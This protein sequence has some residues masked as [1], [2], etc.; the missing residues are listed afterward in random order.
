MYIEIIKPGLFTSLQQKEVTGFR[1]MG[2]GPGGAM[3]ELAATAAN[4]LV[5]NDA[6][7]FL[8]EIHFPGPELLF[9]CDTLI[10]FTGGDLQATVNGEPLKN[11]QTHFI[12]KKSTVSFSGLKK[13][14]RAYLSVYGGFNVEANNL[15]LFN[16]TTPLKKGDRLQL[17]KPCDLLPGTYEAAILPELYNQVYTTEEF[18]YCIP[19]P[20]WELLSTEA[21]QQLRNASFTISIQSNRMGYRLNGVAVQHEHASMLSSAADAGIVQLLPNGL[22]VILMSAHQTTGGYPRILSVLSPSRAKLAQ[23]PPGASLRFSI[24]SLQE[25]AEKLIS[26][27][28]LLYKLQNEP[29]N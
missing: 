23:M 1:S 4:H 7:A 13:G 24:I 18:V 29:R 26:W 8:L 20:E 9:H 25:A 10:A 14:Y 16:K 11:W 19:G 3:D 21:Q 2:V 6:Q 12:S 5:R 22:P 15:L 27:R 17:N 28:Q